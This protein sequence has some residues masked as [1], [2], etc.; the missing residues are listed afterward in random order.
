MIEK[1]MGMTCV[2][3]THMAGALHEG[4]CMEEIK[5]LQ[6]RDGPKG[7]CVSGRMR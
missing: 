7:E 1:L 6:R 4:T 3:K 2:V 5:A